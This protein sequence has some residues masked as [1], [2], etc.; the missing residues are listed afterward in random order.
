MPRIERSRSSS[1]NPE[2]N[3]LAVT[4]ISAHGEVTQRVIQTE[5]V[6]RADTIESPSTTPRRKVVP[7]PEVKGE[8]PESAG[9][10][11]PLRE[12]SRIAATGVFNDHTKADIEEKIQHINPI[13]LRE[14]KNNYDG[15]DAEPL[16]F[17]LRN[18]LNYKKIDQNSENESAIMLRNAAVKGLQEVHKLISDSKI[19]NNKY[20]QEL[21]KELE[22]IGL[23]RSASLEPNFFDQDPGNTANVDPLYFNHNPYI[24]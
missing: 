7:L 13:I 2:H 12:L 10:P 18:I 15:P 17:H 9:Q 21:Q 16:E 4:Q 5:H 1:P 3:P 14:A 22:R 8:N 24:Y 19:D 20:I 23:Q 11:K 6:S